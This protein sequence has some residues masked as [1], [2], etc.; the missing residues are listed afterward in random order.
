MGL[1]WPPAASY[2]RPGASPQSRGYVCTGPGEVS[3]LI[4]DPPGT[5]WSP[6]YRYIYIIKVM[7]VLH[8]YRCVT[9]THPAFGRV[10]HTEDE[11]KM[12]MRGEWRWDDHEDEMKNYLTRT[13]RGERKRRRREHQHDTPGPERAN[14]ERAREKKSGGSTDT[15]QDQR[16]GGG[17]KR[18]N[19]P[20]TAKTYTH[21]STRRNQPTWGGKNAWDRGP[22]GTSWWNHKKKENRT[23]FLTS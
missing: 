3:S 10:V 22:M 20:D 19:Q 9:H 13:R 2:M 6:A 4:T 1:W 15:E 16:R 18:L 17:R 5:R 23:Q 21:L 8:L 12:R 14:P 11:V 7:E